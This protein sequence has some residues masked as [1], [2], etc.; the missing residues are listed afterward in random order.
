MWCGERNWISWKPIQYRLC[1]DGTS[2]HDCIILNHDTVNTCPE[3]DGKAVNYTMHTNLVSLF[4]TLVSI[5]A[6]LGTL[7]SHSLQNLAPT[8][9]VS[10]IEQNCLVKCRIGHWS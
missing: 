3:S 8:Y 2:S 7:G 6:M 10:I 4:F 1:R 9:Y 5:F